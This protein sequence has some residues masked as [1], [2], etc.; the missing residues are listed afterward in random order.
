MQR[1]AVF[2][3]FFYILRSAFMNLDVAFRLAWPWLAVLVPVYGAYQWFIWNVVDVVEAHKI[4]LISWVVV[5]MLVLNGYAFATFAVNWHRYAVLGEKARGLAILWADARG[6]R[7]LGN[8]LLI[9][10]IGLLLLMIPGIMLAIATQRSISISVSSPMTW[11]VVSA[12]V[13][14]VTAYTSRLLIKLVAVAVG[15]RL[16]LGGALEATEG[17]TLRIAALTLLLWLIFVPI[18]WGVPYVMAKAG[19]SSELVSAILV[20]VTIFTSVIKTFTGIIT[21]TALYRF[22]IEGSDLTV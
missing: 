7:Y 14:L 19:V 22:F 4:A 8:F 5:G 12:I 17:N 2:E 18:D 20:G 16:T 3:T 1:L 10:L 6:W 11:S 21:L 9:S 13:L 15:N